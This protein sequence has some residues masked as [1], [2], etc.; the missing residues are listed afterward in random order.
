[1]TLPGAI[2]GGTKGGSTVSVMPKIWRD[3]PCYIVQTGERNG[4]PYGRLVDLHEGTVSPEQPADSC[5][6]MMVGSAFETF[7]GDPTPVL[8][9][10]KKATADEGHS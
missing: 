4:L 2:A 1:M 5:A 9:L 3:G 10:L 6:R 7:T 8:E